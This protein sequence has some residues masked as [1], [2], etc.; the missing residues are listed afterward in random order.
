MEAA[1]G[2]GERGGSPGPK[3]RGWGRRCRALAG[4]SVI[5]NG[6]MGI[7]GDSATNSL[8]GLSK[9]FPL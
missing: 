5:C 7:R 8:G 6:G 3:V 4:T 2:I 9:S 1:A